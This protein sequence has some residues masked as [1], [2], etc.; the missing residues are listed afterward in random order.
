[1]A[2]SLYA[3]THT[4]NH[5][6]TEN[7]KLFYW[8]SFSS[9]IHLPHKYDIDHFVSLSRTPAFIR[10]LFIHNHF[11]IWFPS[12]LSFYVCA[13]FLHSSTNNKFEITIIFNL[14]L[15]LSW[16]QFLCI[17]SYH[18]F[19]SLY[20]IS[21]FLLSVVVVVYHV[22]TVWFAVFCWFSSHCFGIR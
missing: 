2:V 20:Y 15:S 17:H 5:L 1:M 16:S 8:L 18:R 21:S 6:K 12:F 13:F 19:H 4:H 9:F 14:V 10:D 11:S 7:Q 22:H 3:H